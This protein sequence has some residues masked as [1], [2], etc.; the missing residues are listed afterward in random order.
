MR[1]NPKIHLMCY[2]IKTKDGYLDPYQV[3]GRESEML[4]KNV[5]YFMKQKNRGW[6]E[7]ISLTVEK[8]FKGRLP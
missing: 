4:M 5:P 7:D 3:S 8:R 2:L 1:T 6:K